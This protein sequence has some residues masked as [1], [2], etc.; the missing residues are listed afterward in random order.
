MYVNEGYTPDTGYVPEEY[1][2][3][4]G[5]GPGNEE[6]QVDLGM[7]DEY[8]T[9]SADNSYSTESDSSFSLD[10]DEFDNIPDG[11][12][13]DYEQTSKIK[14]ITIIVMAVTLIIALIALGLVGYV[15]LNQ[16]TRDTALKRWVAEY[17]NEQLGGGELSEDELNKIINQV[18][19]KIESG[20][21][22]DEEG[23]VDLSGISDEQL[24]L[25]VYRLREPFIETMSEEE[26]AAMAEKLMV[27]YLTENVDELAEL[28]AGADGSNG[29]NGTNGADASVTDLAALQAQIKSLQQ[30]QQNLSKSIETVAST[31]GATGA[32]GAT[33][34][35]GEKGE[36]GEKGATGAAGRNGVD[37]KD[38]ADGRDGEDG[39]DG[40]DGKD[41]INGKDGVDGKDGADGADGK[42]A[43][44]AYA[45]DMNGTNFSIGIPKETS[46]FIGVAN[47]D[48]DSAPTSYEEYVWSQYKDLTV[49]YT[50]GDVPTIVLN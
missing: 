4:Q 25:L 9:T 22:F 50:Q 7:D 30:N 48:A 41:G 5:Y 24:D 32:T 33:G 26:A 11:N 1:E 46:K 44:I 34:L 39:K 21:L 16:N 3:A 17:V 2:V 38:G 31:K 23:N 40:V 8:S 27:T 45:D 28:I 14:K 47:V 43:Y 29:T 35:R 15:M 37:G 12:S 20:N 36:K 18:Q 42:S 49:S 10:D 13:F 19:E 6:E